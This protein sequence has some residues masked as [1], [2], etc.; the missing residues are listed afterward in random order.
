[1]IG[2]KHSIRLL[3]WISE[4]AAIGIVAGLL[5]IRRYDL[6][7]FEDMIFVS[8]M[9]V[10]ILSAAG[11][12]LLTHSRFSVGVRWILLLIISASLAG[13]EIGFWISTV[14]RLPLLWTSWESWSPLSGTSVSIQIAFTLT[15]C[16]LIRRKTAR[17]RLINEG[18]C[19]KCGYS[20]KY[21][22]LP[23]CPECGV[24]R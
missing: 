1:M 21:L 8:A 5:L 4:F 20:L 16:F 3:V 9:A 22:P 23:R 13:V 19:A 7:L 11:Y 14:R 2:I 17:A 6:G 10:T 18:R 12:L 15:M 24:R